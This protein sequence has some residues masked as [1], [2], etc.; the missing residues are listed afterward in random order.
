[1]EKLLFQQ[2]ALEKLAAPDGL[3]DLLR[4]PNT[5]YGAVLAGIFLLLGGGAAW[6]WFGTMA[7]AAEGRAVLARNGAMLS[8]N[9]PGQG[10]ISVFTVH[11]GDRIRPDQIVARIANPVLAEQVRLAEAAVHDA[12]QE[13]ERTVQSRTGAAE[14]RATAIQKERANL[15]REIADLDAQLPFAAEVAA[16]REQLLKEGLIVKQA[17]IEAQQKVASIHNEIQR[18]QAQRDQLEAERF[19]SDAAPADAKAAALDRVAEL[20]RRVAVLREELRQ[21]TTVT[22]PCGG[23]VVEVK[24]YPGAT[25]ESGAPLFTIQPEQQSLEVLAYMPSQQAKL[26]RAGMEAMLT[27]SNVPRE[28]YGYLKANV[29]AI[30]EFPATPTAL[31]RRFE[32]ESISSSLTME[33][34]VSEVRLALR[35]S[36]GD[37]SGYEWSSAKGPRLRL[38][39]GTLCGIHIIIKRQRPFSLVFPLRRE[40]FGLL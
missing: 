2:A 23:E 38:S 28:E 11:V 36:P 10:R 20:R 15:Q 40:R 31:L 16:Q 8:V 25:V 7:T 32:N 13:A 17:M 9:A 29:L 4:I 33:G 30:S 5:Q 19:A 14:L 27:P 22:S 39:S 12:E 35:A 6:G 18:R 37:P 26:I 34:P 3:D 24:A 1:M 21:S